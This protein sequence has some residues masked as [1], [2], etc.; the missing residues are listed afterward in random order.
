MKNYKLMY[1]M[2]RYCHQYKSNKHA[3]MTGAIF[4]EWVK[5]LDRKMKS[6]LIVDNCSSHL[7]IN[8]LESITLLFLPPNTTSKTQ[9]LYAGI[10]K[11]TKHYY[12]RSIIQQRLLALISHWNLIFIYSMLLI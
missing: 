10:I 4:T 3:W 11:N 2:K 12:H 7:C 1:C 9:P 5:A 8:N 6:L